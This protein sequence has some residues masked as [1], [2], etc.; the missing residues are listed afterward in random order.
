M[1]SNGLSFLEKGSNEMAEEKLE[2]MVSGDCAEGCTSPPVCPLYWNSPLQ[3][4]FHDGQSQCEGVWTFNIKEGYYGDVKLS[5]LIV[6]YAFNSPS[7]FPA[8]KGIPWKSIIYIDQKASAQQAEALEKIYRACW[9]EMPGEVIAVKRAKIEF[10]KELI[11]DG[12][13][14]RY[15]VHS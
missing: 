1:Y 11:D 15:T 8:P 13:A 14:A 9:K 10:K 4:Q 5:D 2:W 12:P 3:V 7:S 6:S